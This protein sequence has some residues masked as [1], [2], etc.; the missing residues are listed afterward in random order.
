VPK[1]VK[2]ASG[3]VVLL[4]HREPQALREMLGLLGPRAIR[5]GLVPLESR[6]HKDLRATLAWVWLDHKAYRVRLV[7]LALKDPPA[8]CP[9]MISQR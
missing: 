1:E 6:G 9:S 7:V 3:R 8:K 5:A 4:G 2:E